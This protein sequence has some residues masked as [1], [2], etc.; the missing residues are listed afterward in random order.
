MAE[1]LSVT[2]MLPNKFEPKRKFR[3]VFA[4]EGI[5]AFLMKT[6]ARPSFETSE[7]E[8]PFINSTRYIAGKTKFST[9]AC[10]LY[11]PIA[12]SGAQQ[13][14]EWIRTHFESVSGR[15]GYADFYKRDC[16][17]KLLDPVGTV[18]ELWDIKGAFLTNATF[19]DLDYSG[20]EPT[21][22]SLTMRFDNCVLQY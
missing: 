11:D 10:T 6:A 12:P 2:D 7:Q 4:V 20:E 16:Q 21:E 13:V 8:I 19:G 14:M 5:D 9:L 15:S 22:I 1:T 18:V 3:W 17:L